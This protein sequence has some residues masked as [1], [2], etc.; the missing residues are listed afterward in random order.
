[1]VRPLWRFS[2]ESQMSLS[3]L[4]VH[5]THI[6]FVIPIREM[7][8]SLILLILGMIN[9]LCN[10]SSILHTMHNYARWIQMVHVIIN[11]HS[12]NLNER[13]KLTMK[14]EGKFCQ[15][16]FLE[17][18]SLKLL[19]NKFAHILQCKRLLVFTKHLF[20]SIISCSLFFRVTVTA[21]LFH[22]HQ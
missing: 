16:R 8:K 21:R 12:P 5:F 22:G 6:S 14:I 11:F 20:L 18:I 15:L 17:E 2:I 10:K 1:M 9:K 4:N 19:L 13:F 3:K 7:H